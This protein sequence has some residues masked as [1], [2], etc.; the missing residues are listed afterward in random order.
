MGQSLSEEGS[1]PPRGTMLR[2]APTSSHAGEVKPRGLWPTCSIP[3][4]LRPERRDQMRL[5]D[6]CCGWAAEPVRDVGVPCCV[7]S[8][9]PCLMNG[10]PR[11]A[12]FG[13]Q[14]RPGLAG[15]QPK[16]E[17]YRRRPAMASQIVVA[18]MSQRADQICADCDRR[19]PHGPKQLFGFSNHFFISAA[20]AMHR[21]WRAVL[22]AASCAS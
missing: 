2:I 10:G 18:L 13:L 19:L 17:L 9:K 20:H 15:R 11:P 22:L 1:H 5:T 12:V 7:P 16:I 14:C 6:I 3:L 8:R 21:L 4:S